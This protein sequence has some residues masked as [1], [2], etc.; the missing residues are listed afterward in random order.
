MSKKDL[1]ERDICTQY[2]NP[3]LVKAGWNIKKQVREEVTFT[4]GRIIV[5]GSMHIRG[6]KKRADYILYYKPNVP[7]AIIEAKDNKHNVGDGMQQALEYS[8]ILHIPFVFTS[9]GDSFVFH[10]KTNTTGQVER[11]ITLDEFPSP[12]ELWS[13]HLD[14][15]EI[16]SPEAKEIVSQEYYADDS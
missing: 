16:N 11:E 15:T 12:E 2:I 14:N 9:N 13:K 10:D 4:D 3:A 6:K 5:Q 1:S 7:I 8:E